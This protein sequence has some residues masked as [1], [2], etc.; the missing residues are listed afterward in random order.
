V[1]RARG[2]Q[3]VEAPR[4]QDNQH[5]EVLRSDLSIGHLYPSGNIPGTHFCERLRQSQEHSAAEMIISKKNSNDTLGIEPTA[6]WHV[7][8][9]NYKYFI[10]L[11]YN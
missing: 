5:M 11:S 2:F 4:F 7:A 10:I 8:Q 1:D 6:S 3:E 9:N